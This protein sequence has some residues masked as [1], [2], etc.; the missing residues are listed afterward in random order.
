MVTTKSFNACAIVLLTILISCCFAN[1]D[2]SFPKSWVRT[3]EL[4]LMPERLTD[5]FHLSDR[6]N[7]GKWIKGKL[8]SDEFKDTEL[9]AVCSQRL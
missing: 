9:N 5:E 7:K 1:A 2:K 3:G 8:M 6:A 4:G